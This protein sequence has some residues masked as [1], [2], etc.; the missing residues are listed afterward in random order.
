M[1]RKPTG[2]LTARLRYDDRHVDVDSE[3]YDE[4]GRFDVIR[5]AMKRRK[6]MRP[7]CGRSR[8]A[9]RVFLA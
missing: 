8:M 4:G 2:P 6:G 7:T 3:I 1:S 9:R 5:E